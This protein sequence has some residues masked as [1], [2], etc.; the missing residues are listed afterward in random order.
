M[1]YVSGCSEQKM[2]GEKTGQRAVEAVASFPKIPIISE[3]LG[4]LQLKQ[5]GFTRFCIWNENCKWIR[6][7]TATQ[8]VA[9]IKP[10]KQENICKTQNMRDASN[11]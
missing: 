8:L 1:E 9:C 4:H 7:A 6:E 11:C 3:R 2:V 10:L 5:R